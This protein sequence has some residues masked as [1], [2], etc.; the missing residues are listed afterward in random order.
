MPHAAELDDEASALVIEPTEGIYLETV[1]DHGGRP[2]FH[3]V[4]VDALEHRVDA[5]TGADGHPAASY[6][7]TFFRHTDVLSIRPVQDDEWEWL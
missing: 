6:S 3:H 7:S 2:W 5:M 4:T 1:H